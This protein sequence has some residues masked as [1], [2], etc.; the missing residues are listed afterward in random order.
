MTSDQKNCPCSVSPGSGIPY[1]TL[2][3]PLQHFLPCSLW[4]PRN[5][6]FSYRAGALYIFLRQTWQLL[7]RVA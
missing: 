3:D 6:C 4:P 1:H 2:T 5:I 7:A